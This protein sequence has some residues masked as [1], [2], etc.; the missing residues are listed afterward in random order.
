MSIFKGTFNKS[1]KD[2]LEI[3]QKAINDRTPQNLSYMNSRN[4]WIR[5]SSSVN[6]FTGGIDEDTTAADLNDDGKYDN[7]LA[8]QYVLQGGILNDNKLRAGLGDFSNAY[9]N[10]ASDGTAYQLGIRP[11]PG[12]TNIDIKS[13]GAYGSLREAT[14]NFQCWDI[15][16]LEE[17]EL[18]YMRPGYSVL[19]EWG[20]TPF[21]DNNNKYNTIVEYTDIIN[22]SYTKETLFKLQY[23]KSTDGKYIG[24]GNKEQTIIG[25]QG[26]YD[27]M[28]GIIK[29]YGWTA[30]MDGGY[31]CNTSI[32]SMGEVMESLKVN[33]SPLNNNIQISTKGLIGQNVKSENPPVTLTPS[34][35]KN[36]SK[37]YNQNILAGLFYEL[38]EI[39]RQVG[40]AQPGA[41]RDDTTGHS[42]KLIDSKYTSTYEMFRIVINIKG[43]ENAGSGTGTVGKTDEQI[44]ITLESLVNILNNYVILQDE[45]AKTSFSPLS[46]LE[47]PINNKGVVVNSLTGT[48]YLLSLAHPLQVSTDPTVCLIKNQLWGSGFKV[49]VVAASGSA[50]PNTGTPVITYGKQP[51]NDYDSA[52]WKELAINISNSRTKKENSGIAAAINERKKLIEFVQLS[53]GQNGAAIEELKEIQRRFI[54]IKTTPKVPPGDIKIYKDKTLAEYNNFY[55]V[56]EEGLIRDDIHQAIG[57]RDANSKVVK[58]AELTIA[59]ASSDPLAI[60]TK[61]AAAQNKQIQNNIE[62][63]VEGAR[64]LNQ[65]KLPYFVGND[66]QEEL[67]II[68]NIYVNLNMLYNLSVSTDL[69]AQDSKEKND[70]A[71]YDFVKNILK[72]ISSATGDVN[73]LELFID[74]ADSVTR[75]ID[76][77]YVDTKEN[78]ANAYNNIVEVQ[79]QNLNSV[80][81][82]YKIESQIFPDQ[83]TTVAIG[84][85]VKGGALGQDNNTLVDFNR[86]IIDRVVPRKVDPTTP[87]TLTDPN[88]NLKILID[89]LGVLYTLFG[90]LKSN[91]FGRDGE[92]DVDEAGKYQNS[93]KD[94]I[95]FFKAISTSRTKNKAIIPTKVSLVM[96]G[97]GG[98]VIGNLFKL[99]PNVLPK[100]YRGEGGIGNKIGY[101]VTGLGHSIQNNDWITNIDAQFMILDDPKEGIGGIKVDYGKLTITTTGQDASVT[102][103]SQSTANI[104]EGSS[105]ENNQ[106]YPVLVKS[107]DFKKDYN[108]T[109][110][111]FAKVSTSVSVAD[112]L[113]K[114]LDRKYIT[115]KGGELSTNGDITEDLKS[116]V[117]TFQNK[118]KLTAGFDF[119]NTIG[120]IRITAGNDTYHR[121]YGDKRN[122]TTHS[123]GLAIDIGTRE[124]T[125]TQIDSI[126]NLLRSSGFTYVIYH[127]GSALHI[128]ANISTT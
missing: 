48:G 74:P 5:L 29:N 40:E 56:L 64:L 7:K 96:D 69:A 67:G 77:N 65:L 109:V 13:K 34:T 60:V 23:A 81:R 11:M 24:E 110:Q 124:F 86:G 115:E 71:L 73:N 106:K 22:T 103:G 19:L 93:L 25:Y 35:Y 126:K 88:T 36:L 76:I 15:K 118:L 127:G 20:W 128:H 78:V 44:Y 49:N 52:W 121:T 62:K 91:W 4:A 83:M 31:D 12:I 14:V 55:T 32:V 28:Y 123:R 70:V 1:I 61:Q 17:L 58:G 27:A 82:S 30:R 113:R 26:N 16:Q 84:S 41:G 3:R 120:P 18:L 108:S 97:I 122:K 85:Q 116:A 37:T 59:A 2:Q 66:W 105:P 112:S 101:A 92:F 114:Q 46:V 80:V 94:L 54:E 79:V 39:G 107:E 42:F 90:N 53:V 119:I 111:N 102:P 99:P 47:S 87:S 6:T 21:L 72:K 95:N 68:G 125:Q 50:D 38:W 33:Y 63:G 104:G 8:K 100:G 10:K 9:S 75:I 43:G 57:Y 89:S 45:K 117:L 98:I 51:N